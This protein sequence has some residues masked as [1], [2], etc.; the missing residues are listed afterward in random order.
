MICFI[1][2]DNCH[3]DIMSDLYGG[4]HTFRSTVSMKLKVKS[5][6]SIVKISQFSHKNVNI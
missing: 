1:Y 3:P 6:S 4:E 2:L 5:D